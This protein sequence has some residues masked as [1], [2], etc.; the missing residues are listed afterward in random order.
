MLSNNDKKELR[1]L[2]HDEKNLVNIGKFG[3][4]PTVFESF[5]ISLKAHNLIKVNIQKYAPVTVE[6]VVDAFVKEFDC[7]LVNK[8][9]RVIIFYKY[10][11]E[12]RI[13]L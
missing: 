7:E 4:T 12:G 9:G 5:E 11:E 6:E 8:T 13:K 10:H 3:L 1:K 2:A